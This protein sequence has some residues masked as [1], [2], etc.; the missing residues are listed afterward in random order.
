MT[1]Q[2][3]RTGSSDQD[4]SRS[5]R[6]D[7]NTRQITFPHDDNNSIPVRELLTYLRTQGVE[8]NDV[9]SVFQNAQGGSGDM[10]RDEKQQQSGSRSSGGNTPGSR[11]E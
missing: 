11:R 3:T 4:I 10:N 6:Y 5:I 7:R 1:T 8:P 2:Q 9:L